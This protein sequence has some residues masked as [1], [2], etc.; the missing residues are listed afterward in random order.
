ML[1]T[2]T[3]LHPGGIYLKGLI[4]QDPRFKSFLAFT[5]ELQG[6][7]PS[8]P[9]LA[10]FRKLVQWL[11]LHVF[12][13]TLHFSGEPLRWQ[14]RLWGPIGREELQCERMFEPQSQRVYAGLPGPSCRL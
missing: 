4:S 10:L 11:L 2:K 14:R 8:H 12:Q 5:E 7:L 9:C 1:Q 6:A 13:R 3:A